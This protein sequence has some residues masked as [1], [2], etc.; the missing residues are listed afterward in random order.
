MK[1]S[2]RNCLTVCQR[3]PL[4]RG[5]LR[6]N[7]LTEQIDI[8]QP[9]GWERT[10]TTLTLSLIHISLHS[11]YRWLFA[12]KYFPQTL[13]RRKQSPQSLDVYKRQEI[14]CYG[15]YC[16]TCREYLKTCKGCKPGYLNGCL[17]YTSR[18]V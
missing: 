1:D 6:L 2:I 17:L 9:L 11:S 4:F 3:D 10:S 16:G 8:V 18:C 15:A 14:G 13:H 12:R 7:L 5:A